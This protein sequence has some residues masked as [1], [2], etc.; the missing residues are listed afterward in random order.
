MKFFRTNRRFFAPNKSL[1]IREGVCYAASVLSLK[2]LG[3]RDDIGSWN[4]N[5]FPTSYLRDRALVQNYLKYL[6]PIA[7]TFRIFFPA[8]R[9]LKERT[10]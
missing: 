2:Y 10:S 4:D 3:M 5:I 8:E 9:L 7:G 1:T 6:S